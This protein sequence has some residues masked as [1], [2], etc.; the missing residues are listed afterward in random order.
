MEIKIESREHDDMQTNEKRIDAAAADSY[1]SEDEP[2]LEIKNRQSAT[3]SSITSEA[4][5]KPAHGISISDS[6]KH[7]QSPSTRVT[8]TGVGKSK[9]STVVSPAV[10]ST[11][12]HRTRSSSKMNTVSSNNNDS[13][14]TTSS[15]ISSDDDL[16]N[17]Q[18]A[19]AAAAASKASR[20]DISFHSIR[21]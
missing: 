16:H 10:T 4:S 12:T 5:N 13:S 2:L 8:R 6:A 7:Q 17:K 19:A 14:S 18:A 21:I 9:S 11:N 3:Q 1:S 15:Q 20:L